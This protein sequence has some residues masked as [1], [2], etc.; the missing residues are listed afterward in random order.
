MIIG[1]CETQYYTCKYVKNQ[2]NQQRHAFA[3]CRSQRYKLTTIQSLSAGGSKMSSYDLLIFHYAAVYIT[4]F[5]K[6][7]QL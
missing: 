3:T 5:R 2:Q 6:R 4:E 7:L 1:N